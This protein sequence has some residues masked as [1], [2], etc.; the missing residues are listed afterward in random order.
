MDTGLG[1]FLLY[2]LQPLYLGLCQIQGSLSNNSSRINE[3]ETG[4]EV[5]RKKL[6]K[7]T[8]AMYQQ[9]LK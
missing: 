2:I 7:D 1:K 5:T 9:V 8:E 4:E 3:R 6:T